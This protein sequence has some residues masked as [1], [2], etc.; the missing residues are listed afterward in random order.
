MPAIYAHLKFGRLAQEA[1]PED[2]KTIIGANQKFYNY[3]LHGPDMFFYNKPFAKGGS[4]KLASEI[5]YAPAREFFAPAVKIMAAGGKD[6][7]ALEAYL[8]GYACH[9]ALDRACHS[10]ISKVMSATGTSHSKVESDL[11]KYLILK[12]HGS[13]KAIEYTG[14][15][16]PDR[17]V[18]DVIAVLYPGTSADDVYTCAKLFDRYSSMLYDP[19]ALLKFGAHVFFTFAKG[20]R[21]VFDM[22]IQGSS[23]PS[24]LKYD[25]ALENKLTAEV[26][27]AVEFMREVSAKSPDALDGRFDDN[28]EAKE[29][30][31]NIEL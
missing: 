10:Y 7:N 14:H 20:G 28:F 25:K 31:E 30:W 18:T 6:S 5:H 8:Y 19:S 24:L 2:I 11:E 3:G 15:I 13:Y 22:I 21:T 12:D 1:A 4:V 16:K 17:S 29:G 9:F 27:T 26:N 23:D